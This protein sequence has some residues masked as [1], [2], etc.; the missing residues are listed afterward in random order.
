V[1]DFNGD[2]KLDIV[3]ANSSAV[4]VFLGNGDRTFQA[5]KASATDATI[6]IVVGDF[7]QDGKLDLAISEFNSVS[8]V[9]VF[10]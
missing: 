5:A 2:G 1:A 4:V 3:T 8:D 10:F 9:Q 6:G 7:N